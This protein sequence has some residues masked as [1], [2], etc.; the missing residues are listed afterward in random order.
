M[1]TSA[2][3][4]HLHHELAVVRQ[5][6]AG[7]N[8]ADTCTPVWP[9][10]SQVVVLQA[11]SEAVSVPVWCGLA[12]KLQWPAALPRF[13]STAGAG[14]DRQRCHTVVAIVIAII[15]IVQSARDEVSSDNEHTLRP[16]WVQVGCDWTQLRHKSCCQAPSNQ[17]LKLDVQDDPVLTTSARITDSEHDFGLVIDSAL[18]MSD[19][20]TAVCRSAYA[21]NLIS[22]AKAKPDTPKL[23]FSL[24]RMLWSMVSN[25]AL[26]L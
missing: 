7:W 3:W 18:T 21:I 5:T 25:V 24:S 2:D 6:T 22:Y 17:L 20:V 16:G 26:N 9:L 14:S 10:W 1:W 4:S 19:H 15:A 8:R 11:A 23:L 12:N 13:T